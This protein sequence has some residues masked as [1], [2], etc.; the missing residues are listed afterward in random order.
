MPPIHTDADDQNTADQN[1]VDPYE[2]FDQAWG[3][4]ADVDPDGGESGEEGTEQDQHTATNDGGENPGAKG[5][6]AGETPSTNTPNQADSTDE[7]PDLW[8]DA[9]AELKTQ[10]QALRDQNA[11][12]EQANRSN[13]GRLGAM[14]RQLNQSQPQSQ[15]Q[16]QSASADK[17]QPSAKDVNEALQ[18][19]EK[20]K[21]FGDEYPDIHA[22]VESRMEQ[23]SR[24]NETTTQQLIKDAIQPLQAAETARKDTQEM[25]ALNAA[26][27][28]WEQVTASDDFKSWI[29]QQPEQM[30]RMLDGDTSH[31]VSTVLNIYKGAQAKQPNS[32]V[33]QIK[34]QRAQKLKRST[35]VQTKPSGSSGIPED[36]DGAWDAIPEPD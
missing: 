10:Y 21:V 15:S 13:Q 17:Q 6:N 20:W 22:A 25:A 34:A 33:A 1:T 24:Q 9:P 14:Q 18:T 29:K 35:G 28:D 32:P 31:E 3:E 7:T 8:A 36:F 4:E 2:E 26:H 23:V 19:P 11:K 12:L 27:N 16:S 5:Q 30:R